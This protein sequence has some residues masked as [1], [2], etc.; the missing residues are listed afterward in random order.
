MRA[1]LFFIIVIVVFV[2]IL[3]VWQRI[4]TLQAIRQKEA[5]AEADAQKNHEEKMN[6]CSLCD[7]HIPEN[8]TV[9]TEKGTFCCQEHAN[10]YAEG[11]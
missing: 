9:H 4:Q 7:V 6:Q 2:L 10:R 8:E 5:Q 1:L 11:E 3:V